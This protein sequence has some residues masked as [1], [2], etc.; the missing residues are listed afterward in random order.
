M[1]RCTKFNEKLNI[2]GTNVNKY[3]LKNDLSLSQMSAKLA[4]FGI[5]IPKVSLH[6]IEK[7]TRV[8]KDFE[9]CAIS[10]VLNV[11]IDTLLEDFLKELDEN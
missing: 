11:S 1:K 5:D 4:L 3:R 6:R 2:I 9:L 7:H 10:K 8:V